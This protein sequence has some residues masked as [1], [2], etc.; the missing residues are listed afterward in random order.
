I[1]IAAMLAATLSLRETRQVI[2]R[3]QIMISMAV[4]L[5]VCLPTLYWTA[6]HPSELLAR[7]YKFGINEGDGAFLVALKGIIGFGDAV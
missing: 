4:A 3:P 1:L 6:T 5:L 7:S 2:L